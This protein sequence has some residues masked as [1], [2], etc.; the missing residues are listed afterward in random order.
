MPTKKKSVA[1]KKGKGLTPKALG[2][3]TASKAAKAALKRK[4]LLDSI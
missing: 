2:S 3:G 4:K 1:K